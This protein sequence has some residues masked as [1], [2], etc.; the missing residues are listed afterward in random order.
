MAP[1]AAAAGLVI[2]LEPFHPILRAM[3]YVHTLRHA[4]AL[5]GGRPGTGLVVD[6]AHLWWDPGLVDD[7]A[8]IAGTGYDGWVE[9][10]V[11]VRMP[12][13]ERAGYL[14]ASHDFL[15]GVVRHAPSTP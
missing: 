6:L 5:T 2:G 4:A 7:V 3:T 14:T 12:K 1:M 15:D 10:E 9:D 8:A 11:V 13:E